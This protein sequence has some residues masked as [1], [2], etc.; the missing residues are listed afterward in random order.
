MMS[1]PP[2]TMFWLIDINRS[3]QEGDVN[4]HTTP[5]FRGRSSPA[6]LQTTSR[7]AIVHFRHWP[8]AGFNR[9]PVASPI[10]VVWWHAGSETP[11][12]VV[13]SNPAWAAV[14]SRRRASGRTENR[15]ASLANNLLPR[16][17][18]GGPTH[19]YRCSWCGL[20]DSGLCCRT[21]G[22]SGMFQT[23]PA[24]EMTVHTPSSPPSIQ[25]APWRVRW[26]RYR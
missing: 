22:P 9:Q 11:K 15:T 13:G 23:S 20:F 2:C 18:R 5:V 19:D 17:R 25:S 26:L 24:G 3:P 10:S 8:P 12:R 14:L 7:P 21:N 1:R 16:W 6:P 4:C